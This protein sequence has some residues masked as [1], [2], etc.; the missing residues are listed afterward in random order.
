MSEGVYMTV[1][2]PYVISVA[3]PDY[4]RPWLSQEFGVVDEKSIDTFFVEKVSEFIV[5]RFDMDEI[6]K[7]EDIQHFWDSYYDDFYMANK[8]WQATIF[9]EGK[10]RCANP[11]NEVVFHYIQGIKNK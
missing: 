6:Q 7:V 9:I 1:Y 10:W 5:D 11:S 2:I 4:K 8:P 3:F